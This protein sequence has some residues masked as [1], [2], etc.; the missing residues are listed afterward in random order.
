MLSNKAVLALTDRPTRQRHVLAAILLAV[1]FFSYIDR[2]NVS[3][4]VV[5]PTFL[6]E[7][8][9][10]GN[11][12]QKGLLMTVFLIAY[13]VGNVVLSPLGDRIGAR[14]AMALSIAC[15]ALSLLVG[16]IATAFMTMLVSRFVLGMSEGLHFP[17]QSKYVKEWFPVSERG[18]ANAVWQTGLSIAPAL[19]MPLFTMIIQV[20]GWRSSFVILSALGLIP[21][22]LVWFMTADTPR[23][24]KKVNKLELD[25]IEAG[26]Q[27][28]HGSPETG[29]SLA[30][31]TRSFTR[32]FRFWLLVAYY[33]FHASI[34]WGTI[35]WLPTYLK[36]AKGFSWGE[37]GVLSSLPW[38][39]AFVAKIASGYVCDR[40]GQRASLIFASMV[41]VSLGVLFGAT[42]SNAL[43][44]TILL[45]LGIGALGF[46]FPP[47]WTML[48][49]I[50]P[51]NAIGIGSGLMNGL[52]NG[53]SA[54]A[55]TAIGFVIHMTGSYAYGLYFL[56]CCSAISALIMLFMMLKGR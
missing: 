28:S 20:S 37:M 8:G 10:A 5:D 35:T 1:L 32:D 3:I 38:I 40:T 24:H 30:A 44:A 21:L 23:Q 31:G 9:I 53:F 6:A 47:V 55:P 27:L 50:V 26:L 42:L 41:V 51:R 49:D 56:V 29:D 22:A 39:L 52:A 14:K 17:M 48:Q 18:K 43:M 2:V 16:G 4:L 7:M 45:S 33:S 19:A 36:E 15:W 54:L 34:F 46:A 11:A 12:V 25:H 13:G